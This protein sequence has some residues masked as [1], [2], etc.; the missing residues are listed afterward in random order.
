M[1][2]AERRRRE[3]LPPRPVARLRCARPA[4]A[5][6]TPEL[7]VSESS[8]CGANLVRSWRRCRSRGGGG[9]AVLA[10]R[11]SRLP[12]LGRSRRSGRQPAP[13]PA[14]QRRCWAW[15]FSTREMGHYQPL[16][17][18]ALAA[19]SGAPPSPARVHAAAVLLHAVTAGLLLWLIARLLDRDDGDPPPLGTGAGRRG[20]LRAAPAAGRAGGLGQRAALPAVGTCRCGAAAVV[21]WVAWLRRGTAAWLAAGV[22]LFALS[23]L[24]RVT[25][26]LLPVV[27]AGLV[28]VVPGARALPPRTLALALLPFAAIAAPLAVLEAG[29]RDPAPLGEIGSAPRIAWTLIHPA[30]YVWRTVTGRTPTPVETI[31]REPE[32]EWALALLALAISA[33]LGL[34]TWRLWSARTALVVWGQRPGAARPGR[35]PAALRPAGDGEPLR[36]RSGDGA[37]DRARR[38][39]AAAPAA[40]QRVGL[41]IAATAIAFYASGVRAEAALWRDSLTLWTTAADWA[42]D[43]DVARFNLAL[44]LIDAGRT[45]DAIAQFEAL[46]TRVPY[47]ACRKDPARRTARRFRRTEGG[48]RRRQRRPLRGGG[49]RLF[50]GARPGRPSGRASG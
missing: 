47:Y 3:A 36:L 39:L 1:K 29:A 35:R 19:V 41:A 21:A 28:V 4:V 27:L 38:R 31:P 5:W 45:D 30:L 25:A 42:P 16:S 7:G 26:P 46:V 32:A 2:A 34:A 24:S 33:A 12:Q 9:G 8:R 23:Q 43:D 44:A 49:G 37:V 15:A 14:A 22:G 18:L 11:R 20:T 40:R 13:A 10:D 17:W 6:T 48:R 50:P